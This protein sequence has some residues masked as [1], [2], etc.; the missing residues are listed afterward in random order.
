V[1]W[2]MR[3]AR[4]LDPAASSQARSRT[5]ATDVA[6]LGIIFLPIATSST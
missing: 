6:L 1:L 4:V 2:A 3:L 5:T